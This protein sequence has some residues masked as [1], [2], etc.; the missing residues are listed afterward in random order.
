MGKRGPKKTPAAVKKGRGTYRPDRDAGVELPPAIAVPACPWFLTDAAVEV[1]NELGPALV[2]AQLLTPADAM[3]FA[4][5]CQ[6]WSDWQD[7]IEHL[8]RSGIVSCGDSGNEYQHPA[9]GIRNRSWA[10]VLKGCQEFGLTPSSRT[11]PVVPK[12][13]SGDGA[14]NDA[15][16]NRILGIQ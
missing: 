9:V 14:D 4:L 11:G 2:T 1:W 5:L 6:A 15:A 16:T 3:S 7:A 10:Q 8:K 12:T 13:N